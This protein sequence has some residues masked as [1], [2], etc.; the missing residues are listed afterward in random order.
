MPLP[1]DKWR[2]ITAAA[3]AKKIKRGEDV[4]KSELN[5]YRQW[6][7][8]KRALLRGINKEL[9]RDYVSRTIYEDTMTARLF[10][11]KGE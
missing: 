6:K 1:L 3:T 11:N 4:G 2:E 8:T 10:K 9:L 7:K 5:T